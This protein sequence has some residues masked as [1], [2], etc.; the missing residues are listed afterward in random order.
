MSNV[1]RED[2]L[3]YVHQ[4]RE[5]LAA[6]EL[7]KFDSVPDE[8]AEHAAA[9]VATALGYCRVFGLDAGEDEGVLPV[10]EALGAA[11]ALMR[12]ITNLRRAVDTLPEQW[13]NA[14]IGEEEA[15]CVDIVVRRMD[16]WTASIALNEAALE[17]MFEGDPMA[18][19][20]CQ[21]LDALG[22]AVTSLDSL[23]KKEENL[24]L[25]STLV[26]TELLRNWRTLL[27][28]PYASLPPYWLDGT[29]EETAERVRRELELFLS[30]TGVPATAAGG[31]RSAASVIRDITP[32]ALA[33]DTPAPSDPVV[34]LRWRSPSGYVAVLPCPRK[35]FHGQK[36]KLTVYRPDEEPANELAG[37][38]VDCAGI[39]GLL[40]PDAR[41][42]IL[43]DDL[44]A[45]ANRSESLP[46][47]INDELWEELEP[48]GGE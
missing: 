1:H 26:D 18:E 9:Q 46:L 40:G 37:A 16:V 38:R 4:L 35:P 14:P 47:R 2:V 23:M 31:R 42:E 5:A 21:S 25:L 11:N 48:T 41:V 27:V 29:L 13:D 24:E 8:A 33:A 39:G 22:E 10:P 44:L 45:F 15:V 19:R 17:A 3:G 20:L 12:E 7:E 32:I 43:L 36:V 28:E 30:Q 6:P 34:M